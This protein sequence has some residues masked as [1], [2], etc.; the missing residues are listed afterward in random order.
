[1]AKIIIPTPLRKFTDNN[2]S[3]ITNATTVGAAIQ[4][5]AKTYEPLATH[6]YDGKKELRSFLK[7]YLGENDINILEKSDTVVS[8]NDI[9]SIVPAIAGGSP[10]KSIEL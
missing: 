10:F 5:L 4:D 6:L 1:M 3:F 9:I 8:P 2:A 7:I